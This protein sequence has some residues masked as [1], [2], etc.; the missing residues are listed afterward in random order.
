[1]SRSDFEKWFPADEFADE[2]DYRNWPQ[3]KMVWQLDN[4]DSAQQKNLALPSTLAPGWY[5]AMATAQNKEGETVESRCYLSIANPAKN[6]MPAPAISYAPNTQLSLPPGQQALFTHGTSAPQLFII[7]QQAGGSQP[8]DKPAPFE[9]LTEKQGFKQYPVAI[10]EAD[11][12]GLSIHRMY[13]Y[14]NRF[15]SQQW[16]VAVPWSNKELQIQL[17]TFRNKLEPGQ[18]EKWTVKISG[19]GAEKTTAELLAAMYDASLDAIYPHQWSLP[20]LWPVHQPYSHFSSGRSFENARSYSFIAP[21]KAKT[22]RKTYDQLFTPSRYFFRVASER[23]R[24]Y[25]SGGFMPAAP[26]MAAEVA[27]LDGDGIK[28]AFLKQ[29]ANSKEGVEAAAADSAIIPQAGGPP[30]AAADPA[31]VQI[32]K[33]FNETAFFLPTLHTDSSGTVSFEFTMPEALTQ[34][35]L[36]LL[37]HTPQL[38]MGLQTATTVTQKELMLQPNLPRTLR[39]TDNMEL[40]AKLVNMGD[41][42]ITGTVT[43]QLVNP[44]TGNPVDGWLKNVF[45]NQYFTAAARQSSTV[46]F[47][48]EIP[49]QYTDLLS[50]RLIATT[51][52]GKLSDG[53]E[54]ILPVLSNRLL[55]TE[56]LPITL[57]GGG[58]QKF[59]WDKLA[60]SASSPTLQ[61]HSLTVE[62]STNPVWY[63]I[64]ALPY[65]MEYPY[66]CAEQTFNRY[67]ANALASYI[68]AKA[69]R[70]QQV[71]AA[72][73]KADSQALWSNLQKNQELKQILLEE[74]PWV[75]A[76]NNEATQKKNLAL[77][78][79]LHRMT[80]EGQRALEQLAQMQSPN[81]GFVWFKGGP[82][83]RYITQYIATGIGRLQK[84]G[85]VPAAHQGQLQGIASRAV[86]YL[87]EAIYR[88][89]QELQRLKVNMSL[90]HLSW[91]AQG[92]MYMRS[93]Y[94]Q[95]PMAANTT[96]AYQYYLG[97]LQKY[98]TSQ[99]K[100]AQGMAALVFSRMGEDKTAK[101]IL[102]S[103]T[104]NSITH[105]EMG[106][107][108][109]EFNQ[110]GYYWWQAPIESHALLTETYA[111]VE[112]NT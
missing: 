73:S 81:G 92:Y 38:A 108:W 54:A 76:A 99:S 64:Q 13:V 46:K 94:A 2:T 48:L 79:D 29:D 6:Q 68:L 107:Y 25:E 31:T 28:M 78:M 24:G 10:T 50:Y 47:P 14:N 8:A 43:L 100:Y 70:I 83:D 59:T 85:A 74:T 69:P 22:Y 60:Q 19:E 101:T 55:V 96:T 5:V 20:G 80:A 56:S 39:Q 98:W 95:A 104:E 33:N 21:Y 65:L 86:A 66:D 45:P 12:G 87:D 11:R 91:T 34:W 49:A 4:A 102:Q 53:E 1:M 30:P 93:L 40:V 36:Q 57:K 42:E 58:T 15:Y 109:K 88:E 27:D 41:A 62:Y 89:Y 44:A 61:H 77:L 35:K 23:S 63:A 112:K 7:Q 37:A 106:M 67:Y 51:K 17:Q 9:Y 82:D 75:L 90:N 110:A 105:P 71:L 97:Q 72:W 16:Q 32:R 26:A 111:E 84:L 52:D 18:Q 3:G 103:L